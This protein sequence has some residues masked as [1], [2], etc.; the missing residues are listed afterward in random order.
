[1]RGDLEVYGYS[2]LVSLSCQSCS[3][4][5]VLSNGGIVAS[6]GRDRGRRE[7]EDLLIKCFWFGV[8][9]CVWDVMS[10]QCR[11]CGVFRWDARGIFP[12]QSNAVGE[13]AVVAYKKINPC[14]TTPS[15]Q[16]CLACSDGEKHWHGNSNN[17]NWFYWYSGDENMEVLRRLTYCCCWFCLRSLCG[18]WL[19]DEMHSEMEVLV[20]LSAL[21]MG[22]TMFVSFVMLM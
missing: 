9:L 11:V 2:R 16:R 13:I 18:H 21:I 7:R 20:V 22:R 19:D 1:M 14:L 15:E 10:T 3:T 6:H 4:P 17:K 12:S 5:V 8:L